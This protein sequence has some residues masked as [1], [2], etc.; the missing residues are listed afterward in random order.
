MGLF[1]DALYVGNGTFLLYQLNLMIK[2]FEG[3]K[4]E[5]YL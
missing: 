2:Y 5:N 4:F 3:L 1:F